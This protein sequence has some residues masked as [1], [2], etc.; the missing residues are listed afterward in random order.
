MIGDPNN[1]FVMGKFNNINE[2]G[3]CNNIFSMVTTTD[4]QDY[5]V[6]HMGSEFWNDYENEK[7]CYLPNKEYNYSYSNYS[8]ANDDSRALD[9]KTLIID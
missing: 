1:Q 9:R 5:L 8:W 2:I 6:A 4:I 3:W 7:H